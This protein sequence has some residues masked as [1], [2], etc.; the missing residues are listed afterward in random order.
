MVPAMTENPYESPRDEPVWAEVIPSPPTSKPS[1][2]RI[3][4]TT[5]ITVC[6]VV[7]AIYC[8]PWTTIF[9]LFFYYLGLSR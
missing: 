4:L 2:E 7:L 9:E 5:W 1:N 3:E 8:V 6:V